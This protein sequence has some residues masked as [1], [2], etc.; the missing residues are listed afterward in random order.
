M[1]QD[2]QHVRIAINLLDLPDRVS[3]SSLVVYDS[4]LLLALMIARRFLELQDMF[5]T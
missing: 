5:A 3:Q 2:S 1:C 4:I